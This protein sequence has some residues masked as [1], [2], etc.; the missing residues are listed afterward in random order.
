[1]N[2]KKTKSKEFAKFPSFE[3]MLIWFRTS[4]L[5]Y[6]S[7]HKLYPEKYYPLSPPHAVNIN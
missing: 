5:V 3:A 1:M 7:R 4:T 2:I 6:L